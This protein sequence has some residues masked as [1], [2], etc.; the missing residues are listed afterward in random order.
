M[1]KIDLTGNERD[2]VVEQADIARV[3]NRD[4]FDALVSVTHA[5]RTVIGHVE[6]DYEAFG[7]LNG[8]DH[9]E[10]ATAVRVK[11]AGMMRANWPTGKFYFILGEAQGEPTLTPR[12]TGLTW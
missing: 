11:L 8:A 2:V 1:A 12:A 7:A 6:M 9:T 5:G 4:A 3:P 10:K